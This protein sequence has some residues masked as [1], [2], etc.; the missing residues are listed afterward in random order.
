MCSSSTS[1]LWLFGYTIFFFAI[2]V[3]AYQRE[4]NRKFA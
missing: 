3:W 1:L 4:E 2:A